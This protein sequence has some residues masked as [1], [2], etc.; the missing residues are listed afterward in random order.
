[1]E[2][3]KLDQQT[4]R[5]GLITQFNAPAITA[6]LFLKYH[7]LRPKIWKLFEKFA[8]EVWKTGRRRYG[9]Q[10]IAHRI[11]W[12][13]E[14]ENIESLSEDF[15]LNNKFIAYYARTFLIKYPEAMKVE[16]FETR[17]LKEMEDVDTTGTDRRYDTSENTE[18]AGVDGA[19]EESIQH[20]DASRTD[21]YATLRKGE[22]GNLFPAANR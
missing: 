6:D 2:A 14:I 22:Q 11:R 17:E 4:I 7:G 19:S 8:L 5:K 16:F 13:E 12:H 18:R 10:T 20:R 15:K 1:M 3:V 9:A 21:H